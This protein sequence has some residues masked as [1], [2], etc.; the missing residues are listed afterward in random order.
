MRSIDEKGLVSRG[1]VILLA[2]YSLQSSNTII[3]TYVKL[4]EGVLLIVYGVFRIL[5]SQR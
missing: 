1:L 2:V 4:Q 5:N 3:P